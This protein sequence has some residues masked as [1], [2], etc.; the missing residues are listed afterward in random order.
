MLAIFEGEY[1]NKYGV[2][3]GI[4]DLAAKKCLSQCHCV[5]HQSHT[6]CPLIEPRSSKWYL[7]F[8]FQPR[9]K[10][11]APPLQRTAAECSLEKL[12]LFFVRIVWNRHRPTVRF[13]SRV[14]VCLRR[15]CMCLY[16][17]VCV[18]VCVCVCVCM[19]TQICRITPFN[20]EC[21]FCL[22]V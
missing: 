21:L 4:N 5:Y 10:H 3:I 8:H 18:Y 11:S 14:L 19:Y 13:K 17:Y 15:W 16:M 7:K 1:I 22:N 9:S 6:D 2:L 20:L 12:S